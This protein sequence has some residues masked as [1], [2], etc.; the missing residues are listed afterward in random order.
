M[1]TEQHD[2]YILVMFDRRTIMSNAPGW[3]ITA[4]QTWWAAADLAGELMDE[5]VASKFDIVFI[6]GKP[7]DFTPESLIVAVR[8]EATSYKFGTGA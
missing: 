5:A 7:S 6:P 8:T 3:F 4:H 1:L 2:P